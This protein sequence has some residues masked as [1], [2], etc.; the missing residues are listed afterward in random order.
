MF[1][2]LLAASQLVS[3][4]WFRQHSAPWAPKSTSGVWRS[5]RETISLRSSQRMCR[6]RFAR[7]PVSAFVTFCVCASGDF[8]NEGAD[9]LKLP[10]MPARTHR[11]SAN[12]GDRD[13]TF[14]AE[15]RTEHSRRWAPGIACA[16]RFGQSKPAAHCCGEALKTGCDCRCAN[17]VLTNSPARSRLTG[18]ARI[19]S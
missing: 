14:A 12:E 16:L 3:T 17:L 1:L 2:L 19:F 11:R 18:H 9:D 5:N 6:F 8:E 15:S 4:I 13:I 7:N 10:T